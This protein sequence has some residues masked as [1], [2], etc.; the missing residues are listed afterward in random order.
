MSQEDDEPTVVMRAS[1]L[2][3]M[4]QIRQYIREQGISEDITPSIQ[5]KWTKS[6]STIRRC[7]YC[8]KTDE[9]LSKCSRCKVVHYCSKECQK[10][11]WKI[12]KVYCNSCKEG[13]KE[14]KRKHRELYNT[15]L[16]YY[17]L[18]KDDSIVFSDNI[19]QYWMVSDD[20][21]NEE[22]Y[23]LT[24]SSQ[25]EYNEWCEK[26]N[27][28]DEMCADNIYRTFYCPNGIRISMTKLI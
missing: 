3:N 25:H 19:S 12:H 1:G 24:E 11:D 18:H 8:F 2:H 13:S 28:I 7:Q 4:E 5:V 9:K 15:I 17:T 16:E 21:E 20:Y 6:N 14:D 22:K 10:Q 27:N 26:T 23:T